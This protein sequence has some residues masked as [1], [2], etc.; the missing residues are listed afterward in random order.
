MSKRTRS[1]R[2]IIGSNLSFNDLLFNILLGFVMLFVIAFLMINPI[3]K[4]EDIPVKAEFLVVLSWD[5][6]ANDDIDLWMKRDNLQS[7]GFGNKENSPLHLDRDDL[8]KTNDKV[9]VNG[10]YEI[11]RSNRETI[12]MRGIVAGKYYVGVHYYGKTSDIPVNYNVTVMKVNPFRQIYSK[13]DVLNNS[14]E[15]HRLPAFEVDSEGKV[16]DVFTHYL[17]II[18]SVHGAY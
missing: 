13:S 2:Q 5:E 1:S 11:I 3:T 10:V 6:Q 4:K 15:Y 18:P 7:V 16:T 17:D 8:G 12:T 14:R 9:L